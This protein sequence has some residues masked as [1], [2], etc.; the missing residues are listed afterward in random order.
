MNPTINVPLLDLKAQYDTIRD[1]IEPVVREVIESQWFIGGPNVSA[2]EED[3]ASYC[4]TS[5]A[6][7]CASGSDAILL[8][9]MAIGVQPGDQVIVP[10]YTFFSTAGSVSRLGATPVFA[11]I[12][13]ATYNVTVDTI[14]AAASCCDR[15]KAIMP[16]HLFGQAVDMDGM[17]ELGR[18][19]DVPVI[20][21]AAQAIGCR[22]ATG[23]RVGS[24]GDIGCFSFFPSKNLGTFGDGGVCTTNDE[25]Y[26]N[27]INIL[28]NHG[29]Q[30]KYYH[31]V[32]GMNS[33]LDALHAAVLRV[34]LRHLDAWSEGRR[35]NAAFYDEHFAKAGAKTSVTPL[36]DGG[37]PLRTPEPCVAGATHIYNQYVIR[38]PAGV[39]DELRASLRDQ[40]IGNEVYYPVPLHRQECYADLGY[41]AGALPHAEAAAEQTIALP[42]YPELTEEQRLHVV[43]TVTAFVSQSAS[44]TT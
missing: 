36:H 39:R 17:L 7:G 22:D 42:V 1:E 35:A 31:R 37:L 38:V 11:D 6:L 16:V 20:E 5:H 18:E 23:T 32:I 28:R 21:D 13:P 26:A 2:L 40:G 30:P 4:G 34:K 43:Q 19:L 14:R 15:L 25:T 41:D 12:D 27:T 8:A 3:I 10:T 29:G 33:R 24:R 44:V 9:L